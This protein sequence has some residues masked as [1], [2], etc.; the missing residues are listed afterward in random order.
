MVYGR[1]RTEALEKAQALALEVIAD[2]LKHGEDLLTGRA[3][4]APAP[5][6]RR[7]FQALEFATT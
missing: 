3:Q 6:A 1:T 7:R 2:R 4:K 5:G